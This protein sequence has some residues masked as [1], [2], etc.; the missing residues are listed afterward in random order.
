M[1]DCKV[2]QNEAPVGF[3]AKPFVIGRGDCHQC[4]IGDGIKTPSSK[5][6]AAKCW[7]SVRADK[8]DVY[9]VKRPRYALTANGFIAKLKSMLDSVVGKG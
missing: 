8:Q 9:F 2:D 7:G 3:I 5:C 6:A 4:K 1:T